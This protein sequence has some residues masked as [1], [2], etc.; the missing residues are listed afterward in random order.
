MTLGQ[1]GFRIIDFYKG[2][3]RQNL[4]GIDTTILRSHMF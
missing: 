2:V 1:G 3:R 4:I